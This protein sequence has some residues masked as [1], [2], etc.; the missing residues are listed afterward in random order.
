MG[1]Y[2][3][4]TADSDSHS[5]KKKNTFSYNL[6]ILLNKLSNYDLILG[7]EC[8]LADILSLMLLAKFFILAFCYWLI[9]FRIWKVNQ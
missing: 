6:K 7:I 8:L 2:A 1:S 9:I 3:K 4:K 5:D